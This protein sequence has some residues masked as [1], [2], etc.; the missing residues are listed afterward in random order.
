MATEQRGVQYIWC[1]INCV[2]S[3]QEESAVRVRF[4]ITSMISDRNYTTRRSI[5][6]LLQ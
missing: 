3:K 5:T 6:T 1:E 2:I 4:E